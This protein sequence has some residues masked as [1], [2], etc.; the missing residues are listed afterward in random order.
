MLFYTIFS[1][2]I[3]IHIYTKRGEKLDFL[4]DKFKNPSEN[5]K[6]DHVVLYISSCPSF[7]DSDW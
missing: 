2:S 3:D 5:S 7:L 6:L 4:F 1:T